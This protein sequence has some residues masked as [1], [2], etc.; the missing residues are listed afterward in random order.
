MQVITITKLCIFHLFEKGFMA[1]FFV[2]QVMVY[3]GVAQRSACLSGFGSSAIPD[4]QLGSRYLSISHC[5][6]L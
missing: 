2:A 3:S 6:T 5:V 1:L 4:H